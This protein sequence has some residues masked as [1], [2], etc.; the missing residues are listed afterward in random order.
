VAR[1]KE[2]KKERRVARR[3]EGKK[4]ESKIKQR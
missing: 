1:R 4:K 2:G 3:K